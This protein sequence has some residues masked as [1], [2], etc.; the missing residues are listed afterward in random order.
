MGLETGTTISQLVSTN[1][2]GSDLR[3]QGDDHLRLIKAILKAQFPGVGGLGFNIPITA[4]ETELN[5][6]TGVTSNIQTQLNTL[7]TNVAKLNA[8]SGTRIVFY[9][10]AAPTGWTIVGGLTNRILVNGS[11]GTTGGVATHNVITGCNV[12]ASHTHTINPSSISTGAAGTHTHNVTTNLGFGTAGQFT[13]DSIAGTQGTVPPTVSLAGQLTTA[14]NHTH[15]VDIPSTTSS[16]NTA[17]DVWQPIYAA[18]II[19]NKT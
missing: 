17:L 15:T 2:L 12:V 3:S 19:G 14:P 8:P 13:Q 10:A 11:G 4:K 18:T 6:L 7:T 16:V 1:P 9:S 5:F